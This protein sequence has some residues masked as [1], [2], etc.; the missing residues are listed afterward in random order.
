IFIMEN[1]IP[2]ASMENNYLAALNQILFGDQDDHFNECSQHIFNQ[3]LVEIFQTKECSIKQ[4]A[5]AS[6]DWI[7]PGSTSLLLGL[8]TNQTAI[9]L[10]LHYQFVYALLPAIKSTRA[11]PLNSLDNALENQNVTCQVI[12]NPIKLLMSQLLNLHPG[13]VITTDHHHN[14]P[15]RLRHK[16][17]FAAVELRETEHQKSII[18]KESI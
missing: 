4:S 6:C 11:S 16:E 12:L 3:L 9:E 5:P 7:Y 10:L 1:L 13:D 2:L 18:I 8:K 14:S 15:L 17:D